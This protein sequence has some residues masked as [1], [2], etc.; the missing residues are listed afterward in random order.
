MVYKGEGFIITE[1]RLQAK[2]KQ[3]VAIRPV[4]SLNVVTR[5]KLSFIYN[6]K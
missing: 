2:P 6:V 4:I 3:T 5:I 1:L